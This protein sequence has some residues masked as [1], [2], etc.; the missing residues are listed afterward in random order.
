[1]IEFA[2]GGILNMIEVIAGLIAIVVLFTWI[3]RRPAQQEVAD[4]D[5]PE[6]AL[7]TP[8]S[9]ERPSRG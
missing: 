3:I 1:V 9:E 7:E 4:F 5:E 6:I 8:T 2:Q